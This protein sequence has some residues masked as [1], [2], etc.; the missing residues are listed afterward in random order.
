MM[1]VVLLALLQFNSAFAT[2]TW[3]ESHY[4]TSIGARPQFN[5]TS[6]LVRGFKTA[7]FNNP[8][9]QVVGVHSLDHVYAWNNILHDLSIQMKDSYDTQDRSFVRQLNFIDNLFRIDPNAVVNTHYFNQA[10]ALIL[11]SAY[12]DANNARLG[13]GPYFGQPGLN[14]ITKQEAIALLANLD[15]SRP[16]T[17]QMKNANRDNIKALL[18]KLNSAPANLRYGDASTNSAIGESMDPMGANNWSKTGDENN[19]YNLMTSKPAV[20]QFQL[21]GTQWHYLVSVD[22]LH[23]NRYVFSSFNFHNRIYEDQEN[24]R[25]RYD[26]TQGDPFLMSSTGEFRHQ[27]LNSNRAHGLVWTNRYFINRF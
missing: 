20:Y 21:I 14:D 22:G 27:T 10:A 23:G 3:L 5:P 24:N 7:S 15:F 6:P 12:L 18:S 1:L 16:E 9:Q 11:H 13:D 25:I 8:A 26:P 17:I 19:W 4:G 2:N